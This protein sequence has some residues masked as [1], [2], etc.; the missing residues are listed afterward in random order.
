MT[1]ARGD[2]EKHADDGESDSRNDRPCSCHLEQRD[3]GSGQPDASEEMSKKPIWAS[4]L[5]V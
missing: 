5:P 4:V 1:P 2:D 3:L